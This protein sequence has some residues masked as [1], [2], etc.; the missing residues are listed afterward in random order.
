[1]AQHNITGHLGEEATCTYLEQHGYKIV[2]RNWRMGNIEIDII[3]EN[4]T[5]L[6]FVEVKTRT[7]A[8][9][10]VNPEEYVDEHK[11][12]FM[13][14]AGNAYMK[15]HCI[16]KNLRFDISGILWNK[17]T[18]S[19]EEIHYYEDAFRPKLRTA[20]ANSHNGQWKWHRR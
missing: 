4:K 3:A 13:T 1:M 5:D 2:E 6:V 17:Q 20:T 15:H 14:V 11:R 7:A 8:Y 9:A 16:V 12:R 10:D 18:N 19:V